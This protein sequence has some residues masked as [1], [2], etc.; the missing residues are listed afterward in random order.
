MPNQ[1]KEELNQIIA[2]KDAQINDLQDQ[3]KS[4]DATLRGSG[5]PGWLIT[6]KN[7]AY[8]GNVLGVRFE[9]GRA[10]L[11]KDKPNALITLRQLLSD[12]GYQAVEITSKEF[13][14]GYEISTKD[15]PSILDK[16]SR[17]TIMN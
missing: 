3:L 14:S 8:T 12:F 17:P 6:T 10:F 9:N 2:E 4:R 16:V 13:E 15:E 5:E 1:T 7:T 11:P